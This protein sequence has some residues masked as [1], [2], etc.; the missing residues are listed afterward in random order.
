MS[1]TSLIYLGFL[2]CVVALYW[3]VSR[4]RLRSWI[5]L[6][7]SYS[8]CAYVHPWFAGILFYSTLVVY[9][10]ARSIGRS[11]RP[12]LYLGVATTALLAPLV[13]FKYLD[14]L[15]STTGWFL[16]LFGAEMSSATLGLVIPIGLSFYT[17]QGIG[18]LVDVYRTRS[19]RQEGLLSVA[20]FMAFFPRLAAGPIERRDHLLP[21]LQAS[22]SW[23]W[24]HLEEGLPLIVVGLLKKLV[25]ADNIAMYVD[26]IFLLQQPSVWLLVVGSLGFT[27]QIL[28]DFSG[29]TDIARGSARLLG[30]DLFENF[31][32]PYRA[33]SPSDFWRRWHISLST[34]IR[35]YLYIPLGGSRVPSRARF[36]LVLLVAMGLSGLWHGSG[37]TFLL[38]GFYHA[39]LLFAYHVSGRGGRW[40]PKT[41]I[42]MSLAWALMMGFTVAGWFLFRSPSVS[43]LVRSLSHLTWGFSGAEWVAGAGYLGMMLF[44]A[45]PLVMVWVAD[46]LYLR[47][48][49]IRGLCLGAAIVLI[50]LFAQ[51][52]AQ[53]FIYFRF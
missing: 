52:A 38:W 44:F 6:L 26:R 23:D 8:F 13:A 7:A 14:L 5:L 4:T 43:W 39:V 35:D 28:A 37:W 18:Y 3:L 32:S 34:W 19:A 50:V 46:T 29:Y 16:G 51:D 53:D 21:Q 17:L 24:S 48:R 10:G 25:V 36:L 27:V 41:R 15:G 2:A 49:W 33:V 30:I 47:A 11:A 9:G 1:L 45:L 42:G 40:R 22:R 20:L 31:R 12:T